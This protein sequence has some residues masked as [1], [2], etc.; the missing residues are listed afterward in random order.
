MTVVNSNYEFILV[1]IGD[2]GRQSNGVFGNSNRRYAMDQDFLKIP[3]PR[4]LKRRTKNF[5]FVFLGDEAFFLKAYLMKPYPIRSI[6]IT[7][8][9][10]ITEYHV[11][12]GSLKMYLAYVQQGS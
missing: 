6:Q 10:P 4:P 3:K 2:A 7:E 11:Q 12:E 1:D 9:I 5:V 8:I